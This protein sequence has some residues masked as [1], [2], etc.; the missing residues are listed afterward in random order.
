MVV[1]ADRLLELADTLAERLAHLG[2]ALGA[3]HDQRDDHHDDQLDGRDVRH[4]E[5]PLEKGVTPELSGDAPDRFA[6]R[7]SQLVESII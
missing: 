3:E 4:G 2:Q 1:A 5:A 7:R 6:A